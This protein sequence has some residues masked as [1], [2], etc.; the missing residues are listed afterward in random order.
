[1]IWIFVF[2]AVALIAHLVV[3]DHRHQK[4]E[5]AL[6][7]RVLEAHN[8][9]AIWNDEHLPQTGPD[10]VEPPARKIRWTPPV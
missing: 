6:L 7:D 8:S 2:L 4:T 9:R 1:M 3:N 5:R 10:K